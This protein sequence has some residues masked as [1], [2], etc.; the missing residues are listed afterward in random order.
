MTTSS[1][2]VLVAYA[3]KHESTAEIAERIAAAMRSVGC[4]AQARPAS[5]V[6]DL[7]GYAAVVLGSAVYAKRWRREARGFARRHAAALRD[8]PLW[9]FSSGPLGAVEEHPTAPMPPVAERLA[10]ELGARENVMFGGRVPTQP[11]N[12]VE[13]AMAKNTPPERRDA[14]DWPA[15]EAWARGV[16]AQLDAEAQLRS[17]SRTASFAARR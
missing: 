9:L 12:F 1:A 10:K 17:G 6:D 3:S 8:M 2:P 15:I 7:S 5:E 14:R 13:R 4:D 11:G 16:A